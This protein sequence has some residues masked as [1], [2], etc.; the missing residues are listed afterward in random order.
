[1]CQRERGA[2]SCPAFSV[3]G[4]TLQDTPPI[5]LKAPAKLNLHLGVG[6]VRADGYHEVTTVLQA[7]ELADEVELAPA[8]GLS[9]R[10]EPDLGLAAERNLAHR[11]A[12]ALAGALGRSADVTISL[13]KSVPA[14][15][16]LGG[17]SSD[18]A[19]VLR[20]LAR[21]WGLPPSAPEL[22]EVARS[23]G[24]DV[25]FFLYR[26]AALMT[27]RGDELVREL[28]APVIHMVLVWPRQP[29]PTAEA[30]A[31]FDSARPPPAPGP[32]RLVEALEAG[33]YRKVATRLHN[34]MTAASSAL[35]PAITDALALLAGAD[36]VLG[37]EMC[38]SGSA[39]FGVCETGSAAQEAAGAARDRGWWAAAT[40]TTGGARTVGAAAHDDSARDAPGRG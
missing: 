15:A 29:V 31:A 9:L 32:E 30:Y 11:A 40:R 13:R 14:G 5:T 38:G 8:A 12:V 35:V 28:D 6:D 25:P 10:C 26:N 20:G 37:S 16:G 21:L 23:L 2:W 17:G 39:V 4:G 1:M 36:G 3:E 34:D 18:A 7:L 19:A 33:E 24:A 27:G 22:L